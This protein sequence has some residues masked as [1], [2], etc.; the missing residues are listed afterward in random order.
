MLHARLLGWIVLALDAPATSGVQ[1][2]AAV[3][4]TLTNYSGGPN[5]CPTFAYLRIQKTG[6][7][8]L[9]QKILPTLAKKHGQKYVSHDHLEYNGANKAA[10]G[11][12]VTTLR[13]PVERFLSEFTMARWAAREDSAA[14]YSDQWD[15]HLKDFPVLLGMQTKRSIEDAFLDFLHSPHN[16]ARNRQALYLLGFDRVACRLT[17]CGIC[18]PGL[19]GQVHGGYPAHAYDWDRD[20]DALL[21]RAKSHLLSL[22]AYSVTD[23]LAASM[24]PVG[25][26]LGWD[27]EES[28][29]MVSS[30]Q[31]RQ[32]NKTKVFGNMTAFFD[33]RGLASGGST[34]WLT[35]INK[36]L[37]SQIRKVNRVD[38]ELLKFA[39]QQL[40]ERHGIQC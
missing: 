37:E 19:P 38:D 3:D 5:L 18:E 13:D 29:R 30:V 28:E 9:G 4:G 2:P 12:V 16:P 21:A 14:L 40:W 6:S 11:C 27:P 10:E 15:W 8:S 24:K 7:T 17:C 20:H 32:Q 1:L 22:R 23:C 34:S 36:D 33:T 25:L 35:R 39:K 26:A 31:F